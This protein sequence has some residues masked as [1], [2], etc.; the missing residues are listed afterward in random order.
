[1][2]GIDPSPQACAVATIRGIDARIG[3]LESVDYGEMSFDAVVMNHSLEHVVDPEADLRRVL[4]LLR[5]G[6]LLL[7]SVPNFGSWQRRVFGVHWY[8][9]DLPR[10]RTHFTAAAL[11]HALTNA[12]FDVL[13]VGPTSDAATLFASLQ[14]LVAGRLIFRRPPLAWA[15]YVCHAVLSPLNAAIDRA[16]RDGAFLHAVAARPAADGARR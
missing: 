14:Y 4:S 2:G 12:G 9:L 16:R 1:V 10:H 3:T 15:A 13:T 6:G 11:D 5:P 8:P 7:L